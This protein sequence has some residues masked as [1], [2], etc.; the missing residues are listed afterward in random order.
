MPWVGT[1]KAL[2]WQLKVIT[3]L[4]EEKKNSTF[5]RE[6]KRATSKIT[7]LWTSKKAI[8][9]LFW[10]SKLQAFNSWHQNLLFQPKKLCG[11]SKIKKLVSDLWAV[12]VALLGLPGDQDQ[13]CSSNFKPFSLYFEFGYFR[14]LQSKDTAATVGLFVTVM[15]SYWSFGCI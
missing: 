5:K 12:G 11:K 15:Q 1:Q 10:P 9:R 14:R 3:G 2:F 8:K 7:Y 4:E 6:K 13:C